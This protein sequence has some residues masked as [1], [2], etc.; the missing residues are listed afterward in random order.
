M[1][2]AQVRRRNRMGP[3]RSTGD[4]GGNGGDSGRNDTGDQVVGGDEEGESGHRS[5]KD[6]GAGYDPGLQRPRQRG[7]AVKALSSYTPMATHQAV[8]VC[9]KAEELSAAYDEAIRRMGRP[10]GT[11]RYHAAQALLPSSPQQS[12]IRTGRSVCNIRYG[13]VHDRQNPMMH[14]TQFAPVIMPRMC[15]PR[16]ARISGVTDLKIIYLRK[17]HHFSDA[18][19]VPGDHSPSQMSPFQRPGDGEVQDGSLRA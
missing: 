4:E 6:I 13:L 1:K 9:F 18:V 15:C 2:T 8:N 12:F 19:H 7:P 3:P 11:T 17:C 16:H 5:E 10:G 14:N